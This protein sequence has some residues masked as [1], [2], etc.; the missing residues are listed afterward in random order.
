MCS[1]LTVQ[2][3]EPKSTFTVMPTESVF[4]K[5][6]KSVDKLIEN[7]IVGY[8]QGFD[9]NPLLDSSK[10]ADS[11]SQEL[12][13]MHFKYPVF[14]SL[15]GFTNTLFGFNAINTNYYNQTDV[16]TLDVIGDVN[17]EQEMIDEATVSAGY[18]FEYMYFP[19]SEDGT[20]V[21]N[22]FNA[23]GRQDLTGW[24][25]HNAAFR[26]ILR[27]YLSM[28]V[29]DATFQPIDEK[30]FD[31]R[32]QFEYELGIRAT[33]KTKFRFTNQFYIN[34][35]NDPFFGYYNY[36]FGASLVQFATKKLYGIAAFYYQRRNYMDRRCSDRNALE[37][38][39][40]YT[41]TASILYDIAKD[42]SIYVNYTHSENH[43]NEVLEQ[44]TDSVYSAGIYYSF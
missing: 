21:G 30:R 2:E 34:E 6:T 37:R 25:Y 26:I 4:I 16:N 14:G 28:D 35:S 10:K 8:T 44:Y 17:I 5:Q 32:S 27:D 36:R 19:N 1:T 38:D 11:Y 24:A 13:D 18:V 29:R 33:K 20:Y 41:V 22:Q 39:N 42:I 15:L 9:T 23:A 12:V 7:A 43:T 3:Q 31:I 40:L